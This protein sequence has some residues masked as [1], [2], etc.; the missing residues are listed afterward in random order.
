MHAVQS[1][2]CK[3]FHRVRIAMRDAGNL[4]MLRSEMLQYYMHFP[5]PS[6]HMQ[7]VLDFD[8]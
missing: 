1:I 2:E 4:N 6:L 7:F 8:K 3:A 5:Q